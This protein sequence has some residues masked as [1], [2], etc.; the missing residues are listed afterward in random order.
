MSNKNHAKLTQERTKKQNEEKGR[1]S[2]KTSM[3]KVFNRKLAPVGIIS[4]HWCQSSM[5]PFMH[6][7][8]LFYQKHEYFGKFSSLSAP[9][10]FFFRPIRL[11]VLLSL[12][13]QKEKR[14]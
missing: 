12:S 4:D 8:F 9:T 7:V 1:S 13:E 5:F 2:L 6:C 3:T 11:S 10:K 14:I